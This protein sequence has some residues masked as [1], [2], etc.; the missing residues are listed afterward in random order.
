MDRKTEIKKDLFKILVEVYKM[1]GAQ[2]P[3]AKQEEFLDKA[4][5]YLDANISLRRK[6]VKEKK[7]EQPTEH[8]D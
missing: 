4:L 6:V 5:E 7:D 1:D 8:T 2:N 3:T